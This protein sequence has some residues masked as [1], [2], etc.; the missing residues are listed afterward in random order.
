[1]NGIKNPFASKT[2]WG[3]VLVLLGFVGNIFGFDVPKDEIS[4]L[5]DMLSS[6]WESISQLVGVALT[7]WGRITAKK[8]L[9]FSSEG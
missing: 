9:S 1:M 4:G 7:V 3:A 8:S 2:I 5:I 6:N